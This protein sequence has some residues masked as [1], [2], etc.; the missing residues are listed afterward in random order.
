[1]ADISTPITVPLK[2]VRRFTGRSGSA[3]RTISYH[4]AARMII[5]VEKSASAIRTQLGLDW[6][7]AETT[8]WK[9]TR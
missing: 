7:S 6:T 2:I 3:A 1:M 9:P 5:E 4:E 8:L